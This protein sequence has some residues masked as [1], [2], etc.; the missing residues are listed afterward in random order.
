WKDFENFVPITQATIAESF[1]KMKPLM[2]ENLIWF[3]YVNNE[4]VSFLIV[5]PDANPMIK[6]L[7]GKLDLIGK[8][9]FVYKKWRGVNRMRAIVMGTKQKFQNHGIESALFITLGEYVLPLNQY[10][11]LEL[12]WVGD[13]NEKMIAMHNAMGA[14]FGKKHLTMRN[15]FN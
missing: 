8:L 1:K 13:F 2:D 11:E 9:K 12:S 4:P 14:V 5:L 10:T 15:I 7:K 6:P 3:A